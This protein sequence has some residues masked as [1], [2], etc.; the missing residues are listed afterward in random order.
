MSRRTPRKAP[1][2]PPL[3]PSR[4]ALA[5]A[6]VAALAGLALAVALTRL[7]AQAHA[8]V[9]S[10]CAINEAVNCDRVATSRYSIVLGIPV[11]VWGIFGFVLASALAALGLVRRRLHPTWPAGLLALV[12]IV[13]V[14]ASAALAFVSEFLIGSLCLLCAASWLAAV[15]LL[16]AAIRACRPG[17]GVGK[18]L[19]ADVAA[20]RGRPGIAL[21]AIAVAIAVVAATA[22]AY[23]AYWKRGAAEKAKVGAGANGAKVGASG[24]PATAASPP[25]K[26]GSATTGAAEAAPVVVF[27]DYQCPYCAKVHLEVKAASAR[28][29]D[30]RIEKRHFPLDRACNP[31]LDRPFH[32]TACLLARAAICADAQGRFEA[33]DDAL[34][35]NQEARR[36]VDALARSIGLD[37]GR[38]QACLAAPETTRRLEAD[39]T[40]GI[41]A[42]VRATPSFV[43]G[44]KVHSGEL[45]EELLGAPAP[46]PAPPT[47]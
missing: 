27:S 9:A 30:L 25:A 17:G 37:V 43:V 12:A 14:A 26:A 22:M 7:H 13:S 36:P 35:A 3:A 2:P 16:V 28:R 15:V 6:L 11:S 1:P 38:F 10:F 34:Y 45:P 29:P 44:G 24:G 19:G 33:M 5:V 46:A 4:P 32:D 8:G 20:L 21:G 42:G 39:V 40:A 41:R 47:R 23:P 31:L 18:A